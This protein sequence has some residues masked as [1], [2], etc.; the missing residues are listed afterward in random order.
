MKVEQRDLF[1]FA[2]PHVLEPWVVAK[3]LA[4]TRLRKTKKWQGYS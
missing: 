4:E 1:F 2:P 3:K